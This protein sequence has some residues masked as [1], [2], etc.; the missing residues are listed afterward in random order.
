M[1]TL[2]KFIKNLTNIE[3]NFATINK[4]KIIKLFFEVMA[5]IAVLQVPDTNYSRV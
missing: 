1:I 4:D 3:Q 5:S 2:D